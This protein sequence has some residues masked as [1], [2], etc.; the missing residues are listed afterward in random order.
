M[1]TVIFDL[2][3]TL[4]DTSA[5]LIAAANACFQ[6]RGE[7]TPL[8]PVADAGT[9]FAGGRAMLRLGLSRLGREWSEADVDADFPLLLKAYGEDIDRHT[10]LYP[11]AVEA[12]EALRGRGDRVGICTNKP[13]GLAETLL[14][15]LG[16]RDLFQS[17]IGADTLASRKPDPEP[18]RQSVLR[19]GGEV[20][21]SL[22]VGDTVTDRNTARAVGVPVVLVTFGPEGP[23]IARLEPDALLDDY[24][25]LPGLVERLLPL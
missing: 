25:T 14:A 18:Y 2:D 3:G 23:G 6:S 17:L 9:A 8:D 15:R 24:A 19:A 4:A 5:D 7:G 16:V 12:V 11:G 22:L 10:R 13:E 21:C 20:A 1:R